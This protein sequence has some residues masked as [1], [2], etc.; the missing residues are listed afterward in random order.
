M[1]CNDHIVD[2]VISR[3]NQSKGN[4][5]DIDQDYG[6]DDVIE[7]K[8]S[9]DMDDTNDVSFDNVQEEA[10]RTVISVGNRLE[11]SELVQTNVDTPQVTRSFSRKSF[12]DNE[13][14][15][16]SE[17][18]ICDKPLANTQS[19]SSDNICNSSNIPS[20]TSR[21]VST[22]ASSTGDS[23][24]CTDTEISGYCT[25]PRKC[26][27]YSYHTV[28]FNK[29]QGKKSLGFSIVGG[30]DSAKGSIGIFVKTILPSG[31]AAQDGQLIEGIFKRYYFSNQ[32]F[33]K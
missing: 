9:P 4:I 31:Q 5:P 10:L 22:S 12:H 3:N 21:K 13:V 15:V 33:I 19:E 11:M 6:Y 16:E 32:F 8:P 7:L 26:R 17:N 18:N 24:I 14:K 25:L 2:A 27:N 1:E 20:N 30:R 29:G 28:V 23:A